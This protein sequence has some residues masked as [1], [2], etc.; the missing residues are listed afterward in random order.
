[1]KMSVTL[2]LITL[3]LPV[4]CAVPTIDEDPCKDPEKCEIYLL[5]TASD[6]RTGTLSHIDLRT[7]TV[8]Q[9]IRTIH[10]DNRVIVIDQKPFILQRFGSNSLM[11]LEPNTLDPIWERSLRI[12][13][14]PDPNPQDMIE[15]RSNELMVIYQNEPKISIWNAQATNILRDI[16]LSSYTISGYETDNNPEG[17]NLYKS[18]NVI[19]AAL[20]NFADITTPPYERGSILRIEVEDSRETVTLFKELKASPL[21]G[22]QEHNNEIFIS[23]NQS[24]TTIEDEAGIIAIPI[25]SNGHAGTIRPVLTE[26]QTNLHTISDFIIVNNSLGFCIGSN[27]AFQNSLLAFNPQDGTVI[28]TLFQ[29]STD[30]STSKTLAASFP[31]RALAIYQ[32]KLYVGDRSLSNPGIRIFNTETLEE[33]TDSPLNVGLPPESFAIIKHIK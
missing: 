2:L 13:S 18:G 25:L 26:K 17:F 5:V 14:A 15:S 4:F 8:T 32:N 21:G 31:Q 19:F 23:I 1:M 22:M 27:A 20:Q 33:E 3:L 11:S 30:I 9:N 16:D 29:A 28:K 24:W 7:N 10:T 12:P 6:F